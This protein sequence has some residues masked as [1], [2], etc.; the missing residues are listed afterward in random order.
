MRLAI[1]ALW[2]LPDWSA[3]G[4]S[5]IT[6]TRMQDVTQEWCSPSCLSANLQL[7]KNTHTQERR[8]L[9]TL[10]TAHNCPLF[11]RFG[12]DD[13]ITNTEKL[14]WVYSDRNCRLLFG[15]SQTDE[16]RCWVQRAIAGWQQRVRE[17]RSV[18]SGFCSQLNQTSSLLDI[19]FSELRDCDC[20]T[21]ERA[22]TCLWSAAFVSKRRQWVEDQS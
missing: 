21:R 1:G 14:S 5:H 18:C 16:N 2:T 8:R 9:E 3:T 15:P 11:L 6:R 13:K 19:K 10:V 4:A 20:R 7:K 22:P 17:E 12:K